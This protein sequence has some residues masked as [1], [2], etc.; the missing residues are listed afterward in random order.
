MTPAIFIGH[1]S[2]MNAILDNP[3][4]DNWKAIACSIPK[5][6]AILVISAHW[7][8]HGTVISG[9]AN[10]KTIHDFG[11]FPD[12]LSLFQY[13]VLGNPALAQE[14]SEKLSIS[15]NPNMGLD[16][17]AWSVLCK[18]Y[19]QA[20]IPTI[21]MSL[22]HDKTPKQHYEFAQKLSYLRNQGVLI[23]GT[24]NIV[25]NLSAINWQDGN[26][27]P[28]ATKFNNTII[29]LI[30]KRDF[31][32]IINYPKFESLSKSSVPTPEHFWPLLYVLGVSKQNENIKIFNDHVI[33]GS[34][35]MT[36]L[37]IDSL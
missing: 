15:I 22:D 17:G 26:P 36:S 30:N 6:K 31:E 35:S 1:G 21:Q 28:W 2:P 4:T 25:H 9:A 34:I 23:L 14:L 3:F 27:H 5:P 18:M 13:P 12:E 24:G 33:M 19:P 29:D 7:E 37:F 16:H 8:T 32:S 10:P 11:G 20:D